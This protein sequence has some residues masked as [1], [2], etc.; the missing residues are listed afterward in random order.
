MPPVPAEFARWPTPSGQELPRHVSLRAGRAPGI[1]EPCHDN[2]VSV[3]GILR[4]ALT[5]NHC[6]TVGI[7]QRRDI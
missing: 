6:L 1:G 5:S 3:W 2:L 7:H 4:I